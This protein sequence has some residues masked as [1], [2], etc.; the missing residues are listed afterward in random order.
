M[1][2]LFV[3][4]IISLILM[5]GC[6][7]TGNQVQQAVNKTVTT[8]AGAV[9]NT[10]PPCETAYQFG[11]LADGTLGKQTSFTVTATCA[12]GKTIALYIDDE[13][14]ATQPLATN[15]T[16]AL[17]FKL[18]PK[19]EGTRK[20]E[21]KAD[22]VVINTA[23][24]TVASLGSQDTSGS[25]NDPVSV[26]EWVATSYTVE[27]PVTV[28]SVGVFMRRL[29]TETLQNS[30]VIV[31]LR[32]DNGG[33][34]S[35]GV[36]KAATMPITKPTLSENWLWFN[37]ADGATLQPGKYWVVFRVNQETD[38]LVSDVVNVHYTAKDTTTPGNDYT[39]SMLLVWDKN[40]KAFGQTEWKTLPY[41][42]T[43][44]VVL[45]GASH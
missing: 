40:G 32:S 29:Y 34:P 22:G 1:K 17:N 7:Q 13:S 31:E 37:F 36:L 24:W 30:Y 12:A 10:E 11:T 43:Y 3:V 25:R 28:K 26:K 38:G 16:T 44:A 39:R 33:K 19:I 41:D 20:V 2:K 5:A 18:A 27:V 8:A 6:T 14:V 4:L 23:Q 35:D 15:A 45:S 21:V 42:R 9:Q